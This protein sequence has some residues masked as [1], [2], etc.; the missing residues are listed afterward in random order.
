MTT[1]AQTIREA[2]R[3]ATNTNSRP[4]PVVEI[5]NELNTLTGEALSAIAAR[6][7]LGV[8]VRGRMLVTVARDGSARDRW[9]KRPPDSPVIVPIEPARMLAVL[10]DAAAWTKYDGRAKGLVPARPPEWLGA[11]VLARLEWP[12]PYLEAVVEMPTLR[13]DGSVLAVPG[14]DEQTG[15]LFEPLPGVRWPAV[16][17]KPS[18]AEVEAA[19]EALLDPVSE[20]PFCAGSD[21]AAFLAAVLSILARHMIDGPVP[22]FV[23]RA[24]TPGTGKGLLANVIGLIGTGR[25]PPVT[26]LTY[27]GD[28][29]RKR[30]TSLAVGGTALV[31]LDNL[32]GSVGSDAL[33]AALTATEWEDRVLGVNQ[34]VR[35]PLR[36][37]W[38]ATGNNVAFKRT[39]G[40]RVIPIDLDAGIETPEDRDGFLYPDLAV[41]V[42]ARRP[43]LVTAAL[44]L[45]RA[46]CLAGRPKHGKA[47]MGSFEAWDDLVRS[48]VRWGGLDDPAATDDPIRAR[49]RVR[50]QSDDDLESYGALL[51]VLA[52]V[53]PDG[54]AFKTAEVIRRAREDN[55]LGAVL[56]TA[57]PSKGGGHA[58]TQTLGNAFRDLRDRPINGRILRRTKREWCVQGGGE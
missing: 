6:P 58:S 43:E 12:F 52:R 3:A 38:L 19:V 16:P 21:R 23:I 57:A 42:R 44:T 54:Q 32:S 36:A 31:L 50:A 15:L 35:V 4:R 5:R 13:A 41:H 45:L 47:R 9:L 30:V 39:L 26:T 25:V 51:E 17:A 8:Y 37:V 22:M 14:W 49:G 27:E 40:R 18:G 46:F 20:F 48:A 2:V 55:E 28:E 56:D 1:T 33:A 29:L 53:Y 10:D 24:P 11:Q 7:D 34:M